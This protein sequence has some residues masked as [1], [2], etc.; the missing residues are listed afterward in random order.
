MFSYERQVCLYERRYNSSLM[1]TVQWLIFK[2]F[3][4][5]RKYRYNFDQASLFKTVFHVSDVVTD[6]LKVL[7][8]GPVA[9]KSGGNC[10]RE[11]VV[12]T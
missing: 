12:M 5:K 9:L 4:T 8:E 1:L 2:C 7:C 11:G 6:L 10:T 3:K